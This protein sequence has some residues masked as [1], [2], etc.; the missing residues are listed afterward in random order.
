MKLVHYSAKPVGELHMI[1]Q[2]LH[3]L[4]PSGF[5]V[6]DDDCED[7]W[8]SW[9]EAESFGLDRLSLIHDIELK[10]ETNVLILTSP[11]DLRSFS[12]RFRTCPF[13]ELAQYRHNIFMDWK[14]ISMEYAGLIITPYIWE[15][16]LDKDSFWYYVWDCASGCIWDPTAIASI[17][18]RR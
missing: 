17:T 18:L 2:T 5:W 9:C 15:C 13:P 14:A 7:N 11:S 6:S 1:D 3:A 4:K 8:R 16:R 12:E 10:P